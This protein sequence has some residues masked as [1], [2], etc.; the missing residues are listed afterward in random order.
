MSRAHARPFEFKCRIV[1]S[2][3]LV[4][5]Q[6]YTL[7]NVYTRLEGHVPEQIGLCSRASFPTAICAIPSAS[8]LPCGGPGGNALYPVLI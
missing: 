3:Q 4:L 2:Q 8:G 7:C 6:Y 5:Q 1:M